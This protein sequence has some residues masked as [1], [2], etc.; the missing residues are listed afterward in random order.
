MLDN[1]MNLIRIT[2]QLPLSNTLMIGSLRNF[3]Y[4]AKY[5]D[6]RQSI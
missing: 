4:Y 2:I 6:L 3:P 1:C 5:L